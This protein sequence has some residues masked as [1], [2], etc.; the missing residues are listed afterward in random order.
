M[1]HYCN[2]C[3]YYTEIKANY[4]KHLLSQK[5]ILKQG[6]SHLNRYG[7]TDTFT[8]HKIIESQPVVNQKSTFSQPLVNLDTT[9]LFSCNRCLFFLGTAFDKH[10]PQILH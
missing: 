7:T 8:D 4:K 6:N 2:I 10:S 5:H 1:S 9:T 3:N